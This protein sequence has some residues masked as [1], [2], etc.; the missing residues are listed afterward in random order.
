MPQR[1]VLKQPYHP[2]FP[3]VMMWL[4]RGI[5]FYMG[6]RFQWD[7]KG[8]CFEYQMC[9]NCLFNCW[10]LC[11]VVYILLYIF[12]Q[13]KQEDPCLFSLLCS[14]PAELWLLHPIL[15]NLYQL[16]LPIPKNLKRQTMDKMW[17]SQVIIQIW[18]TS[19]FKYA[20]GS[21]YSH[22]SGFAS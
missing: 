6:A 1:I 13:A 2:G 9:I 12:F 11:N 20:I 5:F 4:K 18:D 17:W 3:W 16:H 7:R 15:S 14:I 19:H 10:V 21:Q 8:L 22:Q